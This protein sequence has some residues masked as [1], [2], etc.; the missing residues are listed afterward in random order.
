MAY[1]Y[2][3]GVSS[4]PDG[5][6]VFPSPYNLAHPL[7]YTLSHLPSTTVIISQVTTSRTPCSFAAAK[8]VI[9]PGASVTVTSIYGHAENLE[10]FVVSPC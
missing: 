1:I 7:S 2:A 8:L 10:T 3:W 5:Q 6:L 4:Q 9:A